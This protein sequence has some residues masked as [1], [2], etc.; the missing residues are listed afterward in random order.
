M[1]PECGL[2]CRRAAG[3]GHLL[4]AVAGPIL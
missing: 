3:S 1:A 4:V 2:F